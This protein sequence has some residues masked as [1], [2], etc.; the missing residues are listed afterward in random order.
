[1]EDV[2]WRSFE[3][4]KVPI[5]EANIDNIKLVSGYSYRIDSSDFF[6]YTPDI[7]PVK[8]LK[9]ETDRTILSALNDTAELI[10]LNPRLEDGKWK[11]QGYGYGSKILHKKIYEIIASGK[12]V[13]EVSVY[14][15]TPRNIKGPP[16]SIR[17]FLV[18]YENGK[19][20]SVD[21][22][23]YVRTLNQRLLSLKEARIKTSK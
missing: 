7:D 16:E 5:T 1:M 11:I 4:N 8:I 13:H 17:K 10:T 9:L 12:K 15:S 2:D 19:V 3:E 23:G 22:Y 20:L 18:F 14:A 6:N 21:Y